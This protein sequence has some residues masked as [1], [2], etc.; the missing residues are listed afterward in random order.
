MAP[1][2]LQS[3]KLPHKT[4]WLWKVGPQVLPTRIFH[5]RSPMFQQECLRQGLHCTLEAHE[6]C[7]F[8]AGRL[9]VGKVIKTLHK[10][11]GTAWDSEI[12]SLTSLDAIL[13][14]LNRRK[15]RRRHRVTAALAPS[16]S[17]LLLCHANL[18]A[19]SASLKHG[20][21]PPSFFRMIQLSSSSA[22][23]NCDHSCDR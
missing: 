13:I 20:L 6:S 21:P 11:G 12:E 3:Q 9:I 2:H 19:S 7:T 15:T 23:C 4:K 10:P 1:L 5:K 22:R 18:H 17:C 16:K 8:C 14:E